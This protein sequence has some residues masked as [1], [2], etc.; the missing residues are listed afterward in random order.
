M[1]RIKILK[2]S[3]LLLIFVSL[4]LQSILAQTDSVETSVN[5]I[6]QELV[7]ESDEADNSGLIDKIEELA[8][9][10]ININKASITDLLEIPGIDMTTANKIIAYRD[11]SGRIFSLAELNSIKGLDKITINKISIFLK[12][13]NAI[14][15]TNKS[16]RR[17][18][19]SLQFRN[20]I[21][22]N[23][24]KRDGFIRN[25]FEGNN[26]KTYNRI[27]ILYSHYKG[28]ITLDKDP[29]EKP[30]DDLVS[31]HFSV[32]DFDI[33]HKIIIGD[34]TTEFG[35][36]LALGSTGF[37]FIGLKNPVLP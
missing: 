28:G 3:F 6:I 21:A 19:F 4:P 29:G 25:K 15:S 33:I 10:P 22:K 12:V 31:A 23:L 16:A 13:E 14:K 5:E 26:L 11:N 20:R 17:D 2:I 18:L 27:K 32:N 34:Y 1:G 35:Q 8:D 7:D 36:G 30:F 9:N 37:F 24:Q